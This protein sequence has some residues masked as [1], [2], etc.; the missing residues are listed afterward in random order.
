MN[1]KVIAAMSLTVAAAC[2]LSDST[3]AQTAKADTK[4][5]S[6]SYAVAEEQYIN[7]ERTKYKCEWIDTELSQ[8]EYELLCRLVF[9]ESGNQNIETQYMVAL[10]VLNRLS[11]NLFPETIKEVI[12]APYAYEVTTWDGFEKYGYTEQVER[13]VKMALAENRYASDMFYF[14]TLHY[15][16]FGVPYL[17][18]GDLYFSKEQA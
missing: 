6:S 9:C 2:M 18:S 11:S 13:A 12:Y 4:R 15:H 5:I 14:R 17:Q 8:G 10:T 3:Q 7:I 16:D 1:K